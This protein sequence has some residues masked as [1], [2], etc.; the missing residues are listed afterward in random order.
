MNMDP[1]EESKGINECCELVA[2]RVHYLSSNQ[3][4]AFSFQ[5]L[6]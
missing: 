1:K 3:P 6:S 5:Q 2:R 4:L